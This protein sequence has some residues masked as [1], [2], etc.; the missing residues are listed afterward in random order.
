MSISHLALTLFLSCFLLSLTGCNTEPVKGPST[1]AKYT[2]P[3]SLRAYAAAEIVPFRSEVEVS[4]QTLATLFR[5]SRSALVGADCFKS[6]NGLRRY[7]S[8]NISGEK[9]VLITP[10]L[11]GLNPQAESPN[12]TVR[13][14]FQDKDSKVSIGIVELTGEGGNAGLSSAIQRLT[15]AFQ[16]SVRLSALGFD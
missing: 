5:M 11:I 7:P 15:L 9:T 6:V 10:T 14:N 2:E 4:D 3:L 13:Y 1:E 8:S 12:L 16:E